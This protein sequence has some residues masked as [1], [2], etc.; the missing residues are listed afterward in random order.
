MG[1]RLVTE[2]LTTLSPSRAPTVVRVPRDSGY[3]GHRV[4]KSLLRT[5]TANELCSIA[6][7]TG[8][9]QAHICHLY[10]CWSSDLEVYFLSDPRSLHSR[11]LLTNRSM[12]ISVYSSD[13]PWDRPGHGLQLWGR[14]GETKGA[15]AAKAEREYA[16]RFTGYA[17]YRAHASRETENEFRY[18]FYR[19]I[20]RRIKILD[21]RTFGAGAF[22]TAAIRRT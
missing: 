14:C 12:A 6:T 3:S 4:R 22:V 15:Q 9:G 7:V 17:D 21:E 8:S 1:F 19:F 13:Q 16:K 10:F 2:T 11:N 18:R 20:P 5:L